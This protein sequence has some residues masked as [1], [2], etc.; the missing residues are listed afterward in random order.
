MASIHVV[1]LCGLFS[2][3][4][5]ALGVLVGYVLFGDEPPS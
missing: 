3:V 5:F 2:A 1:A 4:S